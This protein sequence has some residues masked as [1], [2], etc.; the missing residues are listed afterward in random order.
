MIRSWIV[1]GWV[2]ALLASALLPWWAV[3]ERIAENRLGQYLDPETGAWTALVYWRF[4]QWWLPIA[5][6]ISLLA[7]ACMF[8]N[9]PTD[10][11]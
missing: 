8:L 1:G 7:L 11:R 5:A 3:S 2:I 6:P 4:V 10:K 9:R